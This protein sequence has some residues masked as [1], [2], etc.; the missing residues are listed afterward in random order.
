MGMHNIGL[1]TFQYI[2]IRS[3]V[4]QPQRT[5]WMP[6]N[7]IR[8]LI[9]IEPRVACKPFQMWKFVGDRASERGGPTAN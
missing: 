2:I 8:F 3:M 9:N 6:L 1:A 4:V 5:Q 7:L